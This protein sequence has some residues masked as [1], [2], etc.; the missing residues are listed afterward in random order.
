LEERGGETGSKKEKNV[1]NILCEGKTIFIT[2]KR[3]KKQHKPDQKEEMTPDRTPLS[4][5]HLRQH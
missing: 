4:W 2:G 1:I 5:P 3:K